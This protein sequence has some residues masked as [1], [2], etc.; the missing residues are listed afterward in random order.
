MCYDFSWKQPVLCIAV[1]YNHLQFDEL[2]ETAKEELR[3]KVEVYDAKRPEVKWADYQNEIIGHLD[4]ARTE[5]MKPFEENMRNR[6]IK[7]I[8]PI[9]GKVSVKVAL[10]MQ[11]Y[12]QIHIRANGTE[13]QMNWQ[14]WISLLK[15]HKR[16]MDKTGMVCLVVLDRFCMHC[17]VYTATLGNIM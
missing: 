7:M 17:I 10:C 15:S 9:Q 14:N 1:Y 2:H 5:L 12:L 11:L 3:L 6:T 8:K 16:Y 4:K 13:L